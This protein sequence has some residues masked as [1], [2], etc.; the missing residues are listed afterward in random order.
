MALVV[1]D[2]GDVAWGISGG[3]QRPFLGGGWLAATEKFTCLAAAV[4]MNMK[5]HK[6]LIVMAKRPFPG[7]T[8]TRLTPPLTPQQAADLYSCFLRDVLD[9]VRQVPD[10]VPFIAASPPDTA[11]YFAQLAPDFAFIPQIGPNLGKRLH[12]VMVQLLQ[13]GFKQVVAINSDS[14]DLPAAYLAQAFALLQQAAVD[15]VFGP[16]ADGGYYLIGWKRPNPHLIH[17]V[18]MST[19]HVLADSLAIAQA[20]GL[21]VALL[22]TWH[23]V[24][25]TADLARLHQSPT[26]GQHTQQFLQETTWTAAHCPAET[27]VSASSRRAAEATP[28]ENM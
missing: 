1:S 23:D 24:D 11:P 12:F 3:C 18:T 16:C 13:A 26:L 10:I 28:N 20:Q 2:D 22:P 4:Y 19:N 7:Q 17:D 15:V 8:K 21:Q 27:H 25:E 6:A 9:I 14:P 5:S